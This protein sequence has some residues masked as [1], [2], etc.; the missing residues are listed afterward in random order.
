MKRLL[1]LLLALLTAW[2]GVAVAEDAGPPFVSST[3]G[4]YKLLGATE[5]MSLFT[6]I[7]RPTLVVF[8]ASWCLP[9][10]TE[11]PQ[12][13]HLYATYGPSG[14]NVLAMN[15][16]DQ[17]EDSI[18]LMVK[19]FEIIYPVALPTPELT[20]DFKVQAIPAAFLYNAD[21]SLAQSWIGPL[22]A[23]QVEKHLKRVFADK[24][25]APPE[26]R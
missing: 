5:N 6:S 18:K 12:I 13:N 25:P 10:L 23:E 3:K 11:I 7:G 15:M 21:G 1:L 17:S 26:K 14:F 16:D 22:S 9:C 19:R 24:P 20:R 4:T 8:W 2:L